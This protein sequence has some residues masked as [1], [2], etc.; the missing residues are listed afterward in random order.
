MCGFAGFLSFDQPYD[1]KERRHQIL[2][3]MSRALAHRGPDDAQFYDD[4]VLSLVF[5]RLSI[6]DLNTGQQPIFNESRDKF[7]VANG[8]IYNYPDLRR[9]LGQKYRFATK[10][11]CEAPL[12][13]FEEWGRE[14]LK[15]CYGMFALAIWD[16]NK[17][18]L[19]L[20]RDRLGIKPLYVCRLPE[21]LL[22]GSELKALLAHPLCPR[23]LD[24]SALGIRLH[25]HS[26][27]K[28]YLQGIE[29]VAGGSFWDFG[30]DGSSQHGAYWRI[31][32]SLGAA[33]YGIDAGRYTERL[34][35]VLEKVIPE[36]L[37]ADVQMGVYLSGGLDSSLLSAI[38][39]RT[40]QDIP[41]FTVVERTTYRAGDVKSARDVTNALGLPWHPVFFNYRTLLDDIGF[42]LERL[43]QSVWMMDSPRFD[44]EWL[45]KE[46]LH[47]FARTVCPG[48]KVIFLGQGIDEFAGGYSN[49]LDQPM[50]GWMEFLQKEILPDLRGTFARENGIARDIGE[51][52][53]RN[54]FDRMKRFAPFH[55]TMRLKIEHLQYHNLWHEDRS[56]MWH[57]MEARVPFLDH[58][59]VELLASVPEALHERLFWD[60]QIVRDCMRHFLPKYDPQRRKIAFLNTN[61]TGSVQMINHEIIRRVAEE[62][63]EK[64]VQDPNF[65]FDR[66]EVTHLIR[67][68]LAQEPNFV[69]NGTNLLQCMAISIFER[70]CRSSNAPDFHD[71]RS[72]PSQLGSVQESQWRELDVTLSEAPQTG[73][74]W[75]LDDRPQL[76]PGTEM[77]QALLTGVND[78]FL[79]LKSDR[80]VAQLNVTHGHPWIGDFF[81]NLGKGATA[82]FSVQDWIDRF[83]V[84]PEDFF[85]ALSAF[86]QHGFIEFS[87]STVAG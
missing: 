5:R 69:A 4:G 20:A 14:G 19:L 61:D 65:P 40:R 7:I 17:R 77:I 12:H 28:T 26:A 41:C 57:S 1:S 73:I 22:F 43:E 8:E 59:V 74:V 54:N 53:D 48:L 31:E 68:V 75:S 47:R 29:F 62:F 58:R 35:E 37:Q 60:K 86:H 34:E 15:R 38:I 42:D 32:D 80:L 50:A 13:A 30:A 18:R 76:P 23:D 6:V 3:S 79:L 64:Y 51:L 36:H 25:S 67:K 82:D 63:Q 70:Q 27:V 16:V 46:E 11:D 2:L 10:S 45:F 39:A 33:P 83:N 21:G 78:R 85:S 52:L 49:C 71:L 56:S 84:P 66:D 9:E 24:W 55:E 87:K 72:R 81:A 44:L